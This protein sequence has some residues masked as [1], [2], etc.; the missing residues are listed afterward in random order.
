MGACCIA[1]DGHIRQ[2]RI[3]ASP[4]MDPC[5]FMRSIIGDNHILY[6]WMAKTGASYSTPAPGSNIITYYQIR[7]GG[8]AKVV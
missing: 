8:A 7:K 5:S 3:R 6:D 1:R 4:D 2:G